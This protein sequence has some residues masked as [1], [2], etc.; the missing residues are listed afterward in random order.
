MKRDEVA[1]PKNNYAP[2]SRGIPSAC[3]RRYDTT[4]PW[5][6]ASRSTNLRP[7]RCSSVPP[8]GCKSGPSPRTRT[9]EKF[10]RRIDSSSTTS[11]GRRC[12]FQMLRCR[13]TAVAEPHAAADE[14]RRRCAAGVSP[15]V[16]WRGIAESL[17]RQSSVRPFFCQS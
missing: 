2:P 7:R 1:V 9:E 11:G 12:S 14:M 13:G 3:S 16:L 8:R 6:V 10:T 4:C 17:G 5:I 15:Y